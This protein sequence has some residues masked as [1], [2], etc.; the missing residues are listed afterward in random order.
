M[1]QVAPRFRAS[2]ESLVPISATWPFLSTMMT[3]QSLTVFSLCAMM[4]TVELFNFSRTVLRMV[5]SVLGLTCAVGSSK[6]T[7]LLC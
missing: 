2:R 6:I 5:N 7:I 1:D 4:M 3:S